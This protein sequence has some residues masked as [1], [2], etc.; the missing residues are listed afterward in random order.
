MF[1]RRVCL[2][3]SLSVLSSL[4]CHATQ[5][6]L[7][8]QVHYAAKL[9]NDAINMEATILVMSVALEHYMSSMHRHHMIHDS[10]CISKYGS[11][12]DR[13]SAYQCI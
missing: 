9:F 8:A 5:A 12:Y 10:M 2:A 7:A 1:A 4:M 11:I 3:C 6:F 13:E